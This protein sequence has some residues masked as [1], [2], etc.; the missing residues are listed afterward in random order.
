MQDVF[1][2]GQKRA[3]VTDPAA[4]RGEAGNLEV[5]TAE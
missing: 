5:L 4:R 1:I 2:G 3:A